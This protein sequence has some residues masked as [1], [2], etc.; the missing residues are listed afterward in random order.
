M[1]YYYSITERIDYLTKELEK[2]KK[3]LKEFSLEEISK[4]LEK[5]WFKSL[6]KILLNK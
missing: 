4:W 3:K 2:E 1:D 5:D 6:S